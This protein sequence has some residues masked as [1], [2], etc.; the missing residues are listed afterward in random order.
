MAGITVGKSY[1]LAMDRIALL[2]ALIIAVLL[3]PVSAM[4]QRAD[5]TPVQRSSR[6]ATSSK[7][8]RTSHTSSTKS[9][10]KT[11]KGASAAQVTAPMAG[12]AGAAPLEEGLEIERVKGLEEE[13]LQADVKKDK[14][15][16]EDHMAEDLT[17]ATSDGR[18]EN[19]TQLIARYLDPANT[20]ESEK[21]DELN[22]RAVRPF[23][24][25][26]VVTGRLSQTVKGN[27]TQRRFT[28]V[29]VDRGGTL[30]QVATHV[31]AI[32]GGAQANNSAQPAASQP[33]GPNAGAGSAAQSS[34]AGQSPPSTRPTASAS[35]SP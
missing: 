35:P 6:S 22:V 20:V 21:Y 10:G 18:L 7:S 33:Q 15:W 24:D 34:A 4:A 27:N 30:Q 23:G 28:D 25:V 17:S 29:W 26:I 14:R 12:N 8:A 11:S 5:K 9:S 16:F 2:S 19:K 1:I 32:E 31:S 3:A 13:R